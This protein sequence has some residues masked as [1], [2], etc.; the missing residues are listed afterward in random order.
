VVSEITQAQSGNKGRMVV[1]RDF[2]YFL[3]EGGESREQLFDLVNDPGELHPVTNDPDYREQ[4][5]A[6]RDLL[7]EWTG[8]IGDG[9]F[10][11]AGKFPDFPGTGQD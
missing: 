6:H 2:K 9:D 10:D 7:Q 11:A 3:F 5:I 1:T 8:R 4:L